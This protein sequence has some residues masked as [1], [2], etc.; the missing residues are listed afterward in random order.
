[1]AA[2]TLVG[3]VCVL[4]LLGSGSSTVSSISWVG[5]RTKDASILPQHTPRGCPY[6]V[7]ATPANPHDRSHCIRSLG[8]RMLNPYDGTK[9][10]CS[11]GTG[12]GVIAVLN[13]FHQCSSTVITLLRP[14]LALGRERFAMGGDTF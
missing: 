7:I 4:A 10:K 12:M 11:Q 5:N 6:V 1:M 3:R 8:D 14:L 2:L 13:C 9:F